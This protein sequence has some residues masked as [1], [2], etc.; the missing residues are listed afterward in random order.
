MDNR[1]AQVPAVHLAVCVPNTGTVTT[2]F[3]SSFFQ[4]MCYMSTTLFEEGQARTVDVIEKR[5]SNLPRLRQECLEDAILKGANYALFVDSDQSFPHDTA[6]RL[7][8]HK[9]TCVAANIALKTMPSFPTAR[10]KSVS[11]M[12]VPVTSDPWKKGIEKVWRV[13]SGIMLVDLNAVKELPRPWFQITFD[14]P[15]GQL[16]GEDWYFVDKL[17]QAGHEVFIDHDLS[18]LCG[19]VG[20]FVYGHP[21]I[22]QSEV[23]EKAA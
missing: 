6:H 13:G 5:S 23:Q 2:D 20:Q 8:A 21:H 11:P 10:Q 17:Q 1:R 3:W 4:M 15:T 9:K 16:V 12:G 22:P 18:R 7:L 19:H 14:E